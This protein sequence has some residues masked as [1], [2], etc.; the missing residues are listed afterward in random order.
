LRATGPL[1]P[2][3]R[4]TSAEGGFAKRDFYWTRTR[5]ISLATAAGENIKAL[6]ISAALG[7]D[8]QQHYGRHMSS[9][10]GAPDDA[11]RKTRKEKRRLPKTIA[12]IHSRVSFCVPDGI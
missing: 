1:R 8:D 6:P 7:A 3:P 12:N 2:A 9:D 4:E 11:S 5:R 10:F